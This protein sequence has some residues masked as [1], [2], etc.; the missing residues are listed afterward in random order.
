MKGRHGHPGA[1]PK[2]KSFL[3][4]TP[5]RAHFVSTPPASFR[6]PDPRFFTVNCG[7]CDLSASPTTGRASQR[8]DDPDLTASMTIQCC[9]FPQLNWVSTVVS[10]VEKV[11]SLVESIPINLFTLETVLLL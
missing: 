9:G 3:R 10:M 4:L 5:E 2:I 7:A 1:P 11:I 8:P 6:L